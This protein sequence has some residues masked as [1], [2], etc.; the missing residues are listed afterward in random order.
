MFEEEKFCGIV[1]EVYRQRISVF[2]RQWVDGFFDIGHFAIF[3]I[4]P[5]KNIVYLSSHPELSKLYTSKGYGMYDCMLSSEM[6]ESWPFYPWRTSKKGPIIDE[7]H[8]T[9]ENVFNLNCG[10]NF[11]RKIDTEEGRF[12]LI[13]CLSTPKK[14]PLMSY[15]FACNINA[16]LELF[17]FAY[18]SLIDILQNYTN[19]YILPKITEFS[20]FTGGLDINPFQN[21][22]ITKENKIGIYSAQ[23]FLNQKKTSSNE[24]ALLRSKLRL[25]V[26]NAS[27]TN[28][29]KKALSIKKD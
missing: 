26:N 7:I 8:N 14:N 28:D 29:V 6:Y 19:N 23:D 21:Y 10:T 16:I 2:H 3:V 11:V 13:Y 25:V 20:P 22:N 27:I 9:R 18:N 15:I 12:Y 5:N 17:D 4:L 24:S 1:D